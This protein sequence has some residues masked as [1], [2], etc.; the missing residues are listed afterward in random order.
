VRD[1]MVAG[2]WVVRDGR[3][4]GADRIAAGYRRAMRRLAEAT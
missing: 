2:H 3:H 4:H 1:V